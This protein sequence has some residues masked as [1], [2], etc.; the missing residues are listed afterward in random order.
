MQQH[1]QLLALVAEQSNRDIS[2]DLLGRSAEGLEPHVAEAHHCDDEIELMLFQR[3]QRRFTRVDARDRRRI[4][5]VELEVFAENGFGQLTVVH[6]GVKIVAA[7]DEEDVVD[8]EAH[9][10]LEIEVMRTDVVA[11]EPRF[12]DQVP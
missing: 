6:E 8:A 12:D 4:M 1:L 2:V 10:V 7:R 5:Q 3:R 11:A 9:Q